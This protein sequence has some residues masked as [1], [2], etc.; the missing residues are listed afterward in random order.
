MYPTLVVALV[1]RE[2]SVLEESAFRARASFVSD[3]N[4]LVPLSFVFPDT[5]HVDA[6][7]SLGQLQDVE[8]LS[9]DH[10]CV[11][12]DEKGNIFSICSL[13]SSLA[14]TLY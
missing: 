4:T 6:A 7:D 13:F 14:L 5:S 10:S 1:S 12:N 2:T 3:E 11:R 9:A 8:C